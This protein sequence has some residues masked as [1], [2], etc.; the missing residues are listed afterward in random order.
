MVGDFV[1]KVQKNG[2][3]NFEN[4]S[5]FE[6]LEPLLRTVYGIIAKWA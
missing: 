2:W 3:E 1:G 5:H 4:Y 6:N